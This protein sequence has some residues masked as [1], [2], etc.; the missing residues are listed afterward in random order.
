MSGDIHA[1]GFRYFCHDDRG[2]PLDDYLYVKGGD[3]VGNFHPDDIAAAMLIHGGVVV[4]AS[5]YAGKLR[6]A[7]RA[8]GRQRRG[9]RRSSAIRTPTTS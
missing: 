7:L 9:I 8:R 3:D 1:D 4:V 5:G 6:S 2:R